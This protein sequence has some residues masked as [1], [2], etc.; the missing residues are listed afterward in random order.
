MEVDCIGPLSL[1]YPLL[2]IACVRR[3]SFGSCG[4]HWSPKMAI[5][6]HWNRPVT[7]ATNV[8]R[9]REKSERTHTSMIRW[10]LVIDTDQL[11][12]ATRQCWSSMGNF[13]MHG[14]RYMVPIG[15]NGASAAERRSS[16][17]CGNRFSSHHS[18]NPLPLYLRIRREHQMGFKH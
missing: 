12:M 16:K 2:Y 8:G 5:G 9:R 6:D 15:T 10:Q 13:Q 7:M 18:S 3:S 14:L 4:D 1:H 11:S 17:A